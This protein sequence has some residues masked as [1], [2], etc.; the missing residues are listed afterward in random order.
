MNQTDV[1]AP[2]ISVARPT[3]WSAGRIAALAIG[4]VVV[5]LAL[6]LLGAGGTAL[7]ADRTQRDAGY[8]VSDAHTFS[9]GGAALATVPTRLGS[10][11]VGW[12]YSPGMLGKVR[13][14]VTPAQPG[15]ALFVGI[16]RTA[17]ADRYLA[18]VNHTVISEFFRDRT[19]AV[20]GGPVRSAPGRQ[21]FWVASD[22]G[23]GTR[24]VVWDPSSGSWTVVVMNADGR[25]GLE[26]RAELGARVPAA[27][28]I[29]VGL[30]AAGAVLLA[31]GALVIAGAIHGRRSDA[32][33]TAR[34]RKE[35]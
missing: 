24:T 10:P 11:G 17:D 25:P 29:A 15:P 1:A 27:L 9:T 8:V 26:V 21:H 35:E 3:P 30:L 6:A 22:V 33:T 16:A 5:L 2:R 20:D 13:V 23:R 4:A 12:L 32:A 7:W 31:G 34:D 19:R 18:G 14:R 28:W